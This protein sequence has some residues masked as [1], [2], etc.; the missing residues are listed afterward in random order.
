VIDEVLDPG[1]VGIV[2]RGQAVL[3]TLNQCAGNRR[4]N[5]SC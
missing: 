1:E 3:P 5:R 2:D 4:P